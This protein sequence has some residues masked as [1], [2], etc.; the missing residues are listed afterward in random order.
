MKKKLLFLDCAKQLLN[1]AVGSLNGIFGG[2]EN[3]KRNKRKVYIIFE[4]ERLF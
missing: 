3:M 2:Q 1:V 4:N